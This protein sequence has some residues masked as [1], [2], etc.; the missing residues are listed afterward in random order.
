M[1]LLLMTSNKIAN[2]QRAYYVTACSGALHGFLWVW[3][4]CNGSDHESHIG[5]ADSWA[6][7]KSM[8]GHVD[9]SRVPLGLY[10]CVRDMQPDRVIKFYGYTSSKFFTMQFL[11]LD[12]LLGSFGRW[13]APIGI[14]P[15][16]YQD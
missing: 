2:N 3:C 16:P 1:D 14:S 4:V 5:P 7:F 15:R 11:H 13:S 6:T 10:R 9:A 12:M 8:Q